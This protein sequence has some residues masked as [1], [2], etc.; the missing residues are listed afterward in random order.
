MAEGF[1]AF[2]PVVEQRTPIE[3][4]HVGGLRHVHHALAVKT[5]A[6]VEAHQV[7]RTVDVEGLQDLIRGKLL[8][9]NNDASAQ[10]SEFRG[11]ALPGACCKLLELGNAGR[12]G[13]APVRRRLH[14][15]LFPWHPAHADRHRRDHG[16]RP[17]SRT[18]RRA[19]VSGSTTAITCRTPTM[20]RNA[21]STNSAVRGAT[22]TRRK[23][24]VSSLPSPASRVACTRDGTAPSLAT[25]SIRRGNRPG[26]AGAV[27]K[28]NART[29]FNCAMGASPPTAAKTGEGMGMVLY[30]DGELRRLP[31]ALRRPGV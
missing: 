14:H 6:L 13:E 11:Q 23:S 4:H 24:T 17:E 3:K 7:E 30:T 28:K 5:D 26:S 9:A 29:L 22:P 21:C 10:R 1:A 12:T 8:N 19:Q 27:I 25:G 16:A 20:A 2:R 15:H 31:G 18:S